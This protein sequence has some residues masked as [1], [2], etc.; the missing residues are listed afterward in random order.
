MTTKTKPTHE[1]RFP[2]PTKETQDEWSA[3]MQRADAVAYRLLCTAQEESL[4]RALEDHS[5]PWDVAFN[6]ETD[7]G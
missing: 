6:P 3:Y 4:N 5:G 7:H 2:M 1:H